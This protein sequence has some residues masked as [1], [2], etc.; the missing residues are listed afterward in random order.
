MSYPLV[1]ELA[2]DRILVTVTCRVLGFSKQ[3]YYRWKNQPFSNR[4]HAD[5]VI[6][7]QLVDAHLEFPEFGYR[8]LA[9]ELDVSENR[10]HRLCKAQQIRCRFHRKLRSSRRPGPAVCDDLVKRDFTA[11][12][13]DQVWVGDITEHPTT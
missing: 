13:P 9:D 3:G 12:G 1:S 6:T 7:N 8:L 4:D 5:A 10:I 2:V 11:T